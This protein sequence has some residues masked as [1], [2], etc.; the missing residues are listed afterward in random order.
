MQTTIDVQLKQLTEKFQKLL[1]DCPQE[2]N[3]RQKIIEE[4]KNGHLFLTILTS[5]KIDEDHKG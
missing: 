1:N 3:G 2:A 5:F 4:R